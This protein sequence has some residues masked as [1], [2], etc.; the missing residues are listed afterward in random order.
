MSCT[1]HKGVE[2]A[3]NESG[4]RVWFEPV[5]CNDCTSYS[6]LAADLVPPET[7]KNTPVVSQ[8]AY[9]AGYVGRWRVEYLIELVI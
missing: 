8:E 3:W 1:F 5:K 9:T 2:R 7:L 4:T 6:G